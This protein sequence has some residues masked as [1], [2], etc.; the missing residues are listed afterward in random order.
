MIVGVLTIMFVQSAF[1]QTVSTK[2]RQKLFK[3][4]VSV[5]DK[6][7]A[8]QYSDS[9]RLKPPSIVTPTKWDNKAYTGAYRGQYLELARDAARKHRVPE[10][11]FL[12][13]VQ[14]ESNWNPTALSHKGAEVVGKEDLNILE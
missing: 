5:L 14:Q 7:A 1:A 10:S 4:Q 6:R 8:T 12:R 11:L 13:L 2:S 3:S 9:V